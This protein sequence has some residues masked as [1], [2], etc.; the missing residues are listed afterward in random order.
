MFNE[1]N[2]VEAMIIATLAGTGTGGGGLGWTYVPAAQ[3][4]RAHDS[5]FVEAHLREALLRLNPEI[6]AQPERADE[7]IYKLRAVV[8]SVRTDGL[9]RSNEQLAAWLRGEKTLPFGP[10]GEHTPVNLMDF[11]DLSRNRFV[12]TNQFVYRAG[13]EGRLDVVLLV[14]GIPLVIGEAKTPVRPAVTWVD[15][16]DDVHNTYEVNLPALFVPNVFS[17]ATEG[18]EFRYGAIRMPLEMWAPWRMASGNLSPGLSAVQTALT[19]LLRPEVVLDILRY[20]ALFAT[21]KKHRKIKVICRYQQYHGAN[22]IVGRVAEGKIKKG[23]IWHF[24]GSGKSLLMVFAA[25][26]LRLHPKLA[27]PTVLVVVDRLDLDTQISATFN[28]TDIPNTVTAVN[29]EDL[30]LMLSQDVRKVIITTIHKFGEAGGVLNNR[31]NVIALV[32]EAHRTQEGGLGRAMR[33]ALPDAFL[34]GLTGTP[35]NRRDR[36]TFYAF[37]AQED[38]NYYMS[39]YS[40]QDSIRDQATLPLHFESR[41][42]ELRI[43][44]EAIEEAYRNLTG[45]LSEADQNE[46]GRMA[47][48]MAV[49]VKA[50][51]RV[52]N[53]VEDVVTHFTSKVDPNGF[54]AQ[55]VVFDREACVMYKAEFDRLMPREASAVVMSVYSGEAEYK[56]YKLGA[57]EEG[58][59]LDRFRDP[60]DPLKVL[61][62]T[63]KLLTGFD[64]PILQA[65]YLDKPM[66]DHNLLQAICR[67]NRPFAGK[68]YGLIVDYIGIFDDV[69]RALEF[70]EKSVQRAVTNLDEL[71]DQVPG[72]VHACLAF[73]PGVDRTVGGYEGL[74]AAQDRLPDNATRDAYAAAFTLLSKLWEALSPDACL[75]P[76]LAEYRWLAAVYESV[77]PPSGN[78]KLLWHALGA[79]TIEL[80]HQNVHVD[81][82][83][84]DLETF[85]LDPEILDELA[86][87]R[88]PKDKAKEL[89]F[90]ITTRLRRHRGNPKFVALAERLEALRERFEQ[91]LILSVEYLKLL[92]AL[93]RDTVEAEKE[94]DPEEEVD[95][96]TAA[97]TELFDEVKTDKTPIIVERIVKDIDEI[98]RV[99]RFPGWQD[100]SAGEREVKKALRKTLLKYQL[101]QDTELFDKAYGYIKQ[102]Y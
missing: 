33:D 31:S 2:S 35:I 88:D 76:H 69:A 27:N 7:V 85:V 94:V 25:N 18:K 9:V 39:L 24:Q 43:D 61:I 78:G 60:A 26:K 98:V 11:E 59:L 23:L 10:N 70:D 6:A 65:M 80:I 90:K 53:V 52:R 44:K 45:S 92:L 1:M 4:P 58:K 100:T 73:F 28:A 29:R 62:V 75:N 15:G 82:V 14:N 20:F 72:A 74:M 46:L 3:L 56:D 64:A 16:A 101:H 36:N 91:G 49:L 93:A 22:Q 102:Y 63:S 86:S 40:F 99:V 79:K 57:D 66:K 48:K 77:K 21:D 97:L 41:L 30:R 71:K 34:F 68:T 12:V 38:E 50:P 13:P 47:A 81:A 42:P 17:F 83:R 8:L 55:V 5:V 19:G 51:D 37:G 32:D 54:K 67:T 89:A 95:R 87:K 96:A 84:D